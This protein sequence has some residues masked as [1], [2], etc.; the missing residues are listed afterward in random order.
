MVFLP[1]EHTVCLVCLPFLDKWPIYEIIYFHFHFLF[2]VLQSKT[3][4]QGNGVMMAV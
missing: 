1:V 4:V 2:P 3:L